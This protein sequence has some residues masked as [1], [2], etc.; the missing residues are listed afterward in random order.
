MENHLTV[1]DG[2]AEHAQSALLDLEDRRGLV[3]LAK[4]RFTSLEDSQSR[5][6]ADD[7]GEPFEER[8][9]AVLLSE[10]TVTEGECQR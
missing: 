4:E 7:A 1:I 6:L 8:H 10:V 9:G 5:V 2:V 3:A